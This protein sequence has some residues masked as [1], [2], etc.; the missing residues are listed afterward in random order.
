MERSPLLTEQTRVRLSKCDAN[1]L[2]RGF[3]GELEG[4]SGEGRWGLA[5]LRMVVKPV[6]NPLWAG[7][8][9]LQ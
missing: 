7:Y 3:G 9:L 4:R 5:Q 2:V 6:S 8:W 1:E